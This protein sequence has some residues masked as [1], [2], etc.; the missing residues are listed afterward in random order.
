MTK[1]EMSMLEISGSPKSVVKPVVLTYLKTSQKFQPVQWIRFCRIRMFLD[2]PET[3]SALFE[4]IRIRDL[5]MP[6]YLNKVLSMKTSSLWYQLKLVVKRRGCPPQKV[7]GDRG[8][9]RPCIKMN[10]IA[11]HRSCMN[12]I[13]DNP[14]TLYPKSSCRKKMWQFCLKSPSPHTYFA[15]LWC[16]GIFVGLLYKS[17]PILSV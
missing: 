15:F 8:K 17:R 1:L 11:L 4:R 7:R 16:A 10:G 2:L 5:S 6:I 13:E 3:D 14:K 9:S 12:Y